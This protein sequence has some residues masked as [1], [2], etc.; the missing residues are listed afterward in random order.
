MNA[1]LP[2]QAALF[3]SELQGLLEST[4]PEPKAMIAEQLAGS[5]RFQ[6]Q[7]SGDT[8][9]TS[10]QPLF[11]D[12]ALV[13][14]LEI[15][16]DLDLDSSGKY[17]KVMGSRFVLWSAMSGRPLAR[18]EFSP[19]AHSCPVAHWQIHAESGAFTHL[20]TQ[21]HIKKE[22]AVRKPFDLS[23]L[24]LPVGGERLRPCLEDVIEFVIFDC[25]V[26][27]IEG[28]RDALRA[29][30]EGWRRKQLA[31]S[32]RDCPEEAARVLRQLGYAITRA[33]TETQSN[34]DSLRTW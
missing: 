24:H 4:L 28:W 5:H 11:V 13:A 10:R 8:R 32:V 7:P 22:R 15:S 9:A 18:L 3:A 33:T 2:D 20:L 34:L 19:L 29:G 27:R 30:R 26:D 21:A 16:F 14:Q 31:S 25:G 23:T 1:R 17:L 12:V 6:V